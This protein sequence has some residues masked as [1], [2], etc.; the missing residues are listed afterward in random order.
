MEFM[1][2]FDYGNCNYT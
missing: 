2:L 1:L